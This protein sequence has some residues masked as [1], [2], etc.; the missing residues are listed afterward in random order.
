MSK[1][2]S[3]NVSIG[4]ETK[5][6]QAGL[7]KANGMMMRFK[8]TIGSVAGSMGLMFGGAVILQGITSSIRKISD[9]E[10]QM[11][12]VAAVSKATSKEVEAL[13]ANALELG[14][15]S[16]FTSTEIGAM[17]EVMARLGKTS[18][19]ITGATKAVSKLAIATSSELAPAAELMVKTMNAFGLSTLESA[20]VANV[21]AEA[22]AGS[23]LNM[24]DLG[25]SLSYAG[26]LGKTFG[27][28]VERVTAA[29]GVMVDNGIDAS[30][31]G[32]GLRKIF[33]ELST[34]GI[35][36]E[37]AMD[38]INSSSNKVKTS[39]D[40][41]GKTAAA[42]GVILAQNTTKLNTFTASLEDSTIGMN[43]MVN[44]L[45]GNLNNDLKLLGSAFDAVIQEGSVLNKFFRAGVQ[46]M[47]QFLQG[48]TSVAAMM[49]QA[50]E[51]ARKQADETRKLISIQ[52]NVDSYFK[53]GNLEYYIELLTKSGRKSEELIE[54]KRRLALIA[55]E[56]ADEEL[57]RNQLIAGRIEDRQSLGNPEQIEGILHF[58]A[59][60]DELT[61]ANKRLGESFQF[62]SISS[63]GMEENISHIKDIVIDLNRVVQ[64][65]ANTTLY[66]LGE[67]LGNAL[68]GVSSFGDSMLKAVA[69][70]TKELGGMFIALGM[71]KLQFDQWFA[72]PGGAAIAIA[73]GVALVAA[74][75][76]AMGSFQNTNFSSGGGGGSSMSS[77]RLNNTAG[78]S[79][80]TGNQ[81]EIEVSGEFVLRGGDLVAAIDNNNRNNKRIGGLIIGG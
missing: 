27:W 28:S 62:V 44:V 78:L 48:N 70:F 34:K 65:F 66:A 75:T 71:A 46:V 20:R 54:V 56:E 50:A 42:Q 5:R 81:N 6:L 55:K 24:E 16:R 30:K 12:K 11:D 64:E 51:T 52:K 49:D 45:E 72:V 7:A 14:R 60:T 26:A 61:E 35:T 79:G 63:V 41:F 19:E 69:G 38:K 68:S 3:L 9:F 15:T 17:Q 53:S 29:L 25:V 80:L 74:G 21:L 59:V 77:S 10:E 1:T 22:T 47:T 37:E 4:A 36:F 58:K 18:S 43:D 8:K 40:L 57:K 73:A 32:V 67:D 39:F 31:A 33:I 76:A 2:A 23:A 13:T